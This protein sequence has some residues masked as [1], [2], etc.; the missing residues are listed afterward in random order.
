MFIAG[1]DYYMGGREKRKGED[2]NKWDSKKKEK[3]R[4]KKG[5]LFARALHS[6]PSRRL[7]DIIY[8]RSLTFPWMLYEGRAEGPYSVPT[9]RR[10]SSTR[11]H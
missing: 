10:L 2:D 8:Y 7:Y 9:A 3:K 1:P 6:H 4:K 5:R 11:L